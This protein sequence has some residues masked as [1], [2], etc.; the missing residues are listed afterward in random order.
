MFCTKCGTQVQ[1][2]RQFCGNCGTALR[3][4]S[5][6][7]ANPPVSPAPAPV[8]QRTPWSIAKKLTVL[9]LVCV[10][11]GAAGGYWWWQHRPIPDYRVKDPGIYPYQG[12]GPDGTSLKSGF[13]NANGDVVSK[14]QWDSVAH[15]SIVG[16]LVICNEGFCGVEQN[17]KWGYIDKNGKLVIPL[18]FDS[19][20]PFVDRIARVSLGNQV[21]YID[22][23]GT[24]IVTPQFS[25]GGYFHEGLAP[26]K[27][28]QGWGFINTAGKFIIKPK[29]S[30]AWV[31]GF[32]E[33]LAEVCTSDQKCGYIN[34][35]G[36]FAIRPHFEDAATFSDGLGL[37][38]MGGKWGY[39]NHTGRFVI[40]PQFDSATPFS[41]GRAVVE[42][43][44]RVGTI[45]KQ[46]RFVVNPGEYKV[47]MQ[48][49]LPY[50]EVSGNN[51]LGVMTLDG[52]W[53]IQPNSAFSYVDCCYAHA[54]LAVVN[55]REVPV[56]TSGKVLAGWYRGANVSTLASDIENEAS[57]L[58][59]MHALVNAEASYSN[60]F[61][62]IGFA[63]SLAA[64]GPAPNGNSDE[65]HAD[66]IDATLASGAEFNYKF[67]LTIPAG[68]TAGGT[69]YN[70]LLTATPLPGHYGRIFCAD[71]TG[72]IRYASQGQ[73]CST[74]TPLSPTAKSG[75]PNIGPSIGARSERTSL[76]L[77]PTGKSPHP[78]FS[79]LFP[80]YVAKIDAAV[81]RNWSPQDVDSRTAAGSQVQVGLT[82]A[83]DGTIGNIHIVR[84][85][86]SPTLNTSAM[87][88]IAR[89]QNIGSLPTAYSG[90]AL[91]VQ[92]TFTF[93]PIDQLNRA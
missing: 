78:S 3:R 84:P 28:S 93:K 23:H 58:T 85:S 35:N 49:D 12:M 55:N 64:L 15:T 72:T 56:A 14:P 53:V 42:V 34:R 17:G 88:A 21:G 52:K 37:V 60:A 91:S 4:G 86:S 69:N 10:A 90:Q 54:F 77:D 92:F 2:G 73:T 82:I 87:Q 61:P 39:V 40:N 27:D 50:M 45:N 76:Q 46:G 13:V 70:Y 24:Y 59:A 65:K 89:I 44:S 20:S 71:S 5:A 79:H 81:M 26:A 47:L 83:K 6:S 29:F 30:S 68:T 9:A 62:A 51:G 80:W 43:S 22:R 31:G 19:A 41:D 33:G 1:E 32:S 25:A 16:R 67:S 74:S 66:L 8:K 48:D 7:N 38:E 75:P 57:A 63:S 36:T 18:Q 11:A